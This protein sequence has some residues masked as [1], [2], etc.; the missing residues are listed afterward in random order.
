MRPSL[1]RGSYFV[2]DTDCRPAR[3]HCVSY[4]LIHSLTFFGAVGWWRKRG[5]GWFA[6][7]PQKKLLGKSSKINRVVLPRKDAPKCALIDFAHDSVCTLLA[8]YL[9]PKALV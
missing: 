7:P 1:G 8:H 6:T 3:R 2:Y 9:R 5:R 4:S